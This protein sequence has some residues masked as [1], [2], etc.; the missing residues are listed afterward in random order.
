MHIKWPLTGIAAQVAGF[1]VLVALLYLAAETFSLQRQHTPNTAQVSCTGGTGTGSSLSQLYGYAWS[2]NVGWFC[3]GTPWCSSA[4]VYINEDSTLTGYAWSDNIGWIQFGDLETDDMPSGSGTQK[5]NAQ[6]NGNNIQGWVKALSALGSDYGWDGW[7]SLSGAGYGA[8]LTGGQGISG[9]LTG[10][11]WGSDVVGWVDISQISAAA[12]NPIGLAFD[13]SFV[14]TPTRVRA[15]QTSMLS[16]SATCMS[17]CSVRDQNGALIPDSE[18]TSTTGIPTLPISSKTSFI[19]TCFDS[20]GAP[21]NAT[22][23]VNLIPTIQEV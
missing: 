4:G 6:I 19:L 11:I 1:I 14:A 22:V 21:N 12:Q 10:F 3:L 20:N 15:A 23:Q 13:P 5:V 8:Q 16:W 2:E 17:S 18:R 9:P 7:I